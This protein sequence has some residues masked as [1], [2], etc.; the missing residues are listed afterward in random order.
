VAEEATAVLN[1]E[2]FGVG[3]LDGTEL[4]ALFG[5]LRGLRARAGDFQN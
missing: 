4:D 1:K 5:I 3:A 2:R